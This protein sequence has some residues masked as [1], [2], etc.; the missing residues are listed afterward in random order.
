MFF[1]HEAGLPG[2]PL[3]AQ[4]CSFGIHRSFHPRD[5]WART[6]SSWSMDEGAS[7]TARRWCRDTLFLHAWG[8]VCAFSRD[9]FVSLWTGWVVAATSDTSLGFVLYFVG[10]LGQLFLVDIGALDVVK[11]GQF[12]QLVVILHPTSPWHPKGQAGRFA[13]LSAVCAF[14]SAR[15]RRVHDS[16]DGPFH[17]VLPHV[18]AIRRLPGAKTSTVWV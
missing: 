9:W 18:A 14:R 3:S 4:C 7:L 10:I 2:L 16:V 13:V 17:G 8:H 11:A 5:G 6:E 15:R 1:P 12:Y